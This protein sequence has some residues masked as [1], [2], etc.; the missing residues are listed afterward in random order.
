M[1][2]FFLLFVVDVFIKYAWVNIPLKGVIITNAFQLILKESNCK[3]NK[4]QSDEMRKFYD[5]SIN[6][7]VLDNNID[8]YS[9]HSERKSVVTKGFI[10][11]FKE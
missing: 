7:S 10:R 9:V 8:M 3:P 11:T 4:T 2:S 5:Q 6:S 1:N